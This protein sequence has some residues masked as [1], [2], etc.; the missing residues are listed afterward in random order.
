MEKTTQTMFTHT[1]YSMTEDGYNPWNPERTIR[2]ENVIIKS[3]HWWWVVQQL[4]WEN[5]Q[6][7][8]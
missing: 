8:K 3:D 7:V 6:L 1:V 5:R 2:W 4:L